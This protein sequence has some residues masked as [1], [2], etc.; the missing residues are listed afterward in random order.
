MNL[1]LSHHAQTR[2]QQRCIPPIILELLDDCGTEYVQRDGTV[3]KVFDHKGKKRAEQRCG[4]HF[5]RENARYF[6][7]YLVQSATGELI[8]AAWRNKPV[9]RR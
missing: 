3:L 7:V 5:V 6:R 2:I 9:W 1:P 4:R 8:T